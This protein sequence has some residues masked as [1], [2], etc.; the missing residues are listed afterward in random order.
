M[1]F[2]LRTECI[3]LDHDAMLRTSRI[4]DA[5]RVPAAS[6]CSVRTQAQAALSDFESRQ[7]H[8]QKKLKKMPSTGQVTS[9][10]DPLSSPMVASQ[11]RSTDKSA[12]TACQFEFLSLRWSNQDLIKSHIRRHTARRDCCNHRFR[13]RG[14]QLGSTADLCK[15]RL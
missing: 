3:N 7:S 4:E 6:K 1:N 2:A 12:A 11:A 5:L 14:G 9:Q 8:Q 10:A 15:S 13:Q